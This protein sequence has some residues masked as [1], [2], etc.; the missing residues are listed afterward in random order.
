MNNRPL[1]SEVREAQ[2]ACRDLLMMADIS[3]FGPRQDVV[4]KVYCIEHL[5]FRVLD[6][7]GET[8]VDFTAS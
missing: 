7:V 6:A 2:K 4:D 3:P 1:S 5:L 8:N